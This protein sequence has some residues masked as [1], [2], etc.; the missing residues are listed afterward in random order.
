MRPGRRNL[1]GD[2]VA[3]LQCSA[4]FAARRC[5]G[6]PDA[7]SAAIVTGR[8]AVRERPTMLPPWMAEDWN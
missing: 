5:A 8:S 7:D 3:A 2:G 4:C 1:H 6:W